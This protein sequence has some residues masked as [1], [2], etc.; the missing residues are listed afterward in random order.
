M[1]GEIAA[2]LQT[3]I[4]KAKPILEKA[5]GMLDVQDGRSVDLMDVL[6]KSG[7]WFWHRRLY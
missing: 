5:D 2:D 4:T 1:T 3:L 7:L 6:G